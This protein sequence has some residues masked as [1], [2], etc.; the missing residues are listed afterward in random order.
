MV[1]AR[2]TNTLSWRVGKCMNFESVSDDSSEMT[3]VA[4]VL[5]LF[6]MRDV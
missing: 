2:G 3:S 1:D 5:S 4:L 6:S